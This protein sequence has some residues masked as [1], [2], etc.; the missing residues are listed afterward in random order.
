[1]QP[2]KR[3]LLAL[4]LLLTVLVAA[5]CNN[6]KATE[7]PEPTSTEAAPA[8]TEVVL[9]E[10]QIGLGDP[11]VIY[12]LTLNLEA[13]TYILETDDAAP[14]E[15]EVTTGQID[16]IAALLDEVGFYDFDEDYIPEDGSCCDFVY[17]TIQV[18]R[19]GETYSVRGSDTEN[20]EGFLAV[21][22]ALR[23]IAAP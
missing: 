8:L 14:V 13:G 1:M 9:F 23:E 16:S 15:G 11:T 4:T 20:P 6:D 18:T 7:T 22:E 10:E 12:T 2:K 17:Y 3:Y 19:D 5:G 21:R